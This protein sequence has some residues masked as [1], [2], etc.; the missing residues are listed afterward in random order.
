M[1]ACVY[2]DNK[3]ERLMMKMLFLIR[4]H[5]CV[6]WVLVSALC[7]RESLYTKSACVVIH[8]TWAQQSSWYRAGGDFFEAIRNS[9]RELYIVDE[10][11]SF[12][13]SGKLGYR[14]HMQAAYLLAEK[15]MEYDFV[16]LVAHSHGATVGIL[17]SQIL[18][19]KV[20]KGNSLVKISKFYALGV[21]VDPTGLI[22]PD[23]SVI[24][25][26]YNLF[27]F[28]DLVQPVQ[29][30]Y[31]RCFGQHERIANISIV[32]DGFYPLHTQLHHATIGKYLLKIPDFY[33]QHGENNFQLFQH[34]A[35]AEILFY[36]SK[37]PIY[38]LQSDRDRLLQLDKVASGL[39]D[40]AFLRR[41]E[42]QSNEH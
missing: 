20:S 28:G 3:K 19:K 8:G 30:M 16:I 23:M 36:D 1:S 39:L 25:K 31:Q 4:K 38:G 2:I 33:M 21:P 26:F 17:A 10:L 9:M 15:I 6:I 40:N 13:W 5:A 27:S 12:S 34:Q 18:A 14:S 24:D 22:Y 11:I 41:T 32:L 7:T 29:G 35:P 42:K 37:N